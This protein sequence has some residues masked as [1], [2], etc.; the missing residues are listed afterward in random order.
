MPPGELTPQGRILTRADFALMGYRYGGDERPRAEILKERDRVRQQ[1]AEL[2]SSSPLYQQRAK[3]NP[4]YWKTFDV[5]A[6][7]MLRTEG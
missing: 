4:D 5:G 7:R 6:V 3:N 2:F 1:T